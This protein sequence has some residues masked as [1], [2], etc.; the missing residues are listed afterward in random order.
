MKGNI[1][2]ISSRLKK[3]RLAQQVDLEKEIKRLET[4]YKQLKKTGHFGT[5]KRGETEIG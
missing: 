3:Q 2:A 4:E 1:I 5:T